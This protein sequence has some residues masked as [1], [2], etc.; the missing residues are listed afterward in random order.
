MGNTMMAAMS[1]LCTVP[2]PDTCIQ[3][4]HLHRQHMWHTTH[5]DQ[6]RGHR[7]GWGRK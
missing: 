1:E 5:P 3:I 7:W 6:E 4:M 2:A